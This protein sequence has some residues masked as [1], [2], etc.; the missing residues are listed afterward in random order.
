MSSVYSLASESEGVKPKKPRKTTKATAP[1]PIPENTIAET[2]STTPSV[3]GYQNAPIRRLFPQY[4]GPSMYFARMRYDAYYN[5]YDTTNL[6]PN[7]DIVALVNSMQVAPPN[8]PSFGS[9][10]GTFDSGAINSIPW[11]AD[12]ATSL[13]SD[14]VW[15][16]VS[17]EASKSIF[18][19]VYHQNLMSDPANLTVTDK[20]ITYHSCMLGVS[21]TSPG[22]AVALQIT[23]AVGGV[24]GQMALSAASEK[25]WNKYQATFGNEL[26]ANL[27]KQIEALEASLGR[28]GKVLADDP[29]L[30]ALKGQV[31]SI[32]ETQAKAQAK[33]NVAAVEQKVRLGEALNAD[34]LVIK[35]AA[36]AKK[37]AKAIARA[38]K[39]LK[40][41]GVIDKFKVGVRKA[42]D[43]V[44][45]IKNTLKNAFID[46]ISK[47]KTAFLR[48]TAIIWSMLGLS[49]AGAAAATVA[50]GGAASP[51]LAIITNMIIAYGWLDFACNMISMALMMVL[52]A[53]LDRPLANGGVCDPGTKPLDQLIEN[54]SLYFL[55]STFTPIGGLLDAFG[56]YL[57]YGVN[58]AEIILKKPLYIPS[59]FSDAS[60]SL[61]KHQYPNSKIPR[62]EVTSYSAPEDSV[63]RGW[64]ITAG[65]AREPCEGGTWTS[66]DVDMLCNI[67]SYVP[68]TYAKES[69]VPPT[70]I[71]NSTVPQ[72]KPKDTYI[73]TYIKDTVRQVTTPGYRPCP[74]GMRDSALIRGTIGDCWDDL[75]CNTRCWGDWNP[76]HWG[77]NTSCTGTGGIAAGHHFYQRQECPAGYDLFLSLCR[78]SC[79][80]PTKANLATDLFCTGTCGQDE[81][82]WLAFCTGNTDAWCNTAENLNRAQKSGSNWRNVAGVC[83]EGCGP[84]K[85]DVGAL[86]RDNCA[87]GQ[88]EVAGVCW[89]DCAPGT[90]DQGALCRYTCG[91]STP[92]DVAGVCWGSCGNDIDVGA[93]C[94]EHCRSGFHEVAGVCW[95]DR[96]TYARG[97]MTPKSNKTYDPGYNP[98]RN[99]SEVTIPY[100]DFSTPTMLDRMAQ[101]YYDQSTLNPQELEDG[102]ISFEYIIQFY[103][104]VASSELSCDVACQIKTVVFDPVTGGRYEESIG[105]TYPDDPG[106][107]VSYRR[108]YFIRIDTATADLMATK[109]R[110]NPALYNK[111]WPVDNQSLFT[112]TGCTNSDDTAPDAANKSTDP[113][114]DPIMSVPKVF[115][116][117]DRS[118][119]QGDFSWQ[120][121]AVSAATTVVTQAVGMLTGGSL[122]GQV[123]GGVVGGMVGEV[124]TATINKALN[125]TQT[126]DASVEN[127]V[128][129]PVSGSTANHTE[130]YSVM[131]NNDNFQI[132]HGPIYECRARDNNGYVPDLKFCGKINTTAL[133]C[134]HKFVLRD[135]IDMFHIKNP[136]IHIKT[137]DTI[138]PRGKDGCYYKFS[139]VSYDS[140]TNTEGK[141]ATA[142]EF[143]RV[144]EQKDKST[145]VFTPTDTFVTPTTPAKTTANKCTSTTVSE[146][147]MSCYPIRSY[148][149]IE[150]NSTVYPTRNVTSTPTFN[151]RYIRIRPSQT[152]DGFLRISQIGVYDKTGTNLALK[153]P[154]YISG[155][156][157]EG[158]GTPNL[159]VDGTMACRSGNANVWKGGGNTQNSYIDIDLG[160][161]LYVNYVTFFGQLDTDIP[162][163][164]QGV[165]I[166]ILYTNEAAAIPQKQ[167]LTSNT[168]RVQQVDFTTKMINPKLP[169]VPFQVPRPL[170]PEMNLGT[171]CPSRCDN[172]DQISM[173]IQSYNSKVTSSQIVKVTKAFTRS[174]SR[175][176]YEVNMLR[177]SGQ[178]KII[179]KEYISMTATP[180]AN[181][182]NAAGVVYGRIIRVKSNPSM[183]VAAD[184]LNTLAL[185]ISQIVVKNRAN[186]NVAL[187]KKTFA[188]VNDSISA[189]VT[190]GTESARD[191]PN[192]WTSGYAEKSYIEVDLGAIQDI[193]SVTVYGDKYSKYDGVVVEILNSF[194]T[195]AVPLFSSP[196][197]ANTRTYTSPKFPFCSFTY[198][199]ILNDTSSFIQD[200]TPL[201][202]GVDTSGGVLSFKSITDSVVDIY[203]SI[204]NP[205]KISN[206]LKTL[207]SEIDEANTAVSNIVS[208]AASSLQL[209]GCPET[210]CSDPAVLKSIANSY[211]ASSLTVS[212]QY[213]AETN[214]MTQI[215]KAGVSGPNTCDV[216]FTNLYSFYDDYLYPAASSQNTTMVKRF[217]MTNT[218]NCVLQVTA[219]SIPVDL[220]SNAVG[221]IPPASTVN[222]PL[223]VSACQVNCRD[224]SLLASIKTKVNALI[225]A[226]RSIP[227]FTTLLQSFANGANTCEY[228][229]TKDVTKTSPTTLKTRTDKGLQTYI[230]ANV[231]ANPSNCT[232][233]LGTVSEFD[234]EFVTARMDPITGIQTA[235]LNGV[236]VNPPYLFN[237][238]TTTP[239]TRVNETP[240]IL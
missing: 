65:I 68:R 97:S 111:I 38:Q 47:F 79:P 147:D 226:D 60:L 170:P 132:D 154:I 90:I 160:Q 16:S 171:G 139:T 126:L 224:P 168:N 49:Q 5:Q 206:P 222:P 182:T 55:F 86:C 184:K 33:A 11:D 142:G 137:I 152:G 107:Q 108:F 67:S 37:E 188:T 24:A 57:C 124:L 189:L 187:K 238:D 128:V 120:D 217:T 163:C 10:L 118:A 101:F 135:T 190:D 116:F 133:L 185:N 236:S 32:A 44:N 115:E 40:A 166:E 85:T 233:T 89:D 41:V 9:Q 221:I 161:T 141:V 99:L 209:S 127:A 155:S 20:E 140:L 2:V 181:P 117:K 74:E 173:M 223:N 29:K 71:K 42:K 145:C 237:Y 6:A 227:N 76:S 130:I 31:D 156:T 80:E 102:R 27:N 228:L 138:E 208:A 1:P 196:F 232:F 144:Y 3:E 194:E 46:N 103:G 4:I 113:G 122:A 19:K 178:D 191:Y 164:D 123:G 229:M 129:G 26:R 25:L 94:R 93:L 109:N 66:S 22:D 62:G 234:P 167:L 88:K 87:P 100:C 183:G 240:L 198:S 169:V 172:G 23:D 56:P 75:K 193:V 157:T 202:S 69:K 134:S 180:A 59:Y 8:V 220:S 95:G 203:N 215:S 18:T 186:V 131:T 148:Y 159:I 119:K 121:F 218:G 210:K 197:I 205:L 63:P 30:Q 213:G 177:V 35:A 13:L 114:T 43:M 77:C 98:P 151:G 176:D 235:Y 50:T 73:G 52:P 91:G 211:N 165:R 21:T 174:S 54:E 158:Y 72:T 78:S 230:T 104:V 48:A 149:D 179:S 15:G 125:R 219:G 231:T 34:E 12:N 175:C 212:S 200:S 153:R 106:N 84:N 81:T 204:I 192:Y 105:T 239:S 39:E 216:M 83:W 112:V 45:S 92:H 51:L 58:S 82:T 110:E 64:I 195:A 7:P 225:G 36:D 207:S 96:G 14:I 150:T 214:V 201:L 146:R 162:G 70:V 136:S 199:P 28:E 17:T 143:V 61:F 53:L